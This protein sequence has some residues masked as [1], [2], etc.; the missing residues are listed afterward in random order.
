MSNIPFE[1][2]R[3]PVDLVGEIEREITAGSSVSGS[4]LLA[5][6]E[7]SVEIQLAARLR[8]IVSSGRRPSQRRTYA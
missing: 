5:A 7:Q 2:Q 4:D 8:N 3:L 1:K 6:I